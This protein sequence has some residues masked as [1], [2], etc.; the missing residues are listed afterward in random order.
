MARGVRAYRA[1]GISLQLGR[2]QWVLCFFKEECSCL[3]QF[4]V[5]NPLTLPGK[6]NAGAETLSEASVETQRER[7]RGRENMR[8][9]ERGRELVYLGSALT[10]SFC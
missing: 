9:S 10:G 8:A 3:T 5:L 2:R 4:A 6:L 7:E 1:W